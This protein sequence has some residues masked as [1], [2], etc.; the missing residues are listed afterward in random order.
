VFQTG[1]IEAEEYL[2]PDR[3][4]GSA[5]VGSAADHVGADEGWLTELDT[6]SLRDLVRLRETGG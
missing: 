3:L 2:T 4:L 1:D 5:D 6:A